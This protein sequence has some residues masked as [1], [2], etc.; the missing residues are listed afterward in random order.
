M[1]EDFIAKFRRL[2]NECL[3]YM[4]KAQGAYLDYGEKHSKVECEYL[5]R[6]A[7][8]RSE[9]SRIAPERERVCQLR[10]LGE[11]NRQIL[12][13]QS[14]LN[15]LPPK[16]KPDE[17]T[18]SA[19]SSSSTSSNDSDNG[20]SEAEVK[21]WFK[22]QPNH[23]FDDV[24][25]MDG[26][27]KQLRECVVNTQLEDIY[28]FF[29]IKN[30]YSFFFYGPP[31]CGKT[32]I[33]EAFAHELM[34]EGYE[35]ISVVGSDILDKYVGEA[36]AKVTR[37]F[38]EALAHAPCILFIDEIDG[39]CRDRSQP[40]IPVHASSLTT[41]FLTGYNKLKDDD[42]KKVIFIG[43]TNYPEKVDYAMLDRVQIIHVPLPDHEARASVFD[44]KFGIICDDDSMFEHMAD[45]TNNYSYR[46]VERLESKL[47]LSCIKNVMNKYGN[48]RVK[49][50]EA[51]QSGEYKLDWD[52]FLDAKRSC[53]PSPKDKILEKQE[54]WKRRFTV[55]SGE[56]PDEDD[57]PDVPDSAED[58]DIPD[59]PDSIDDI[60]DTD[61]PDVTDEEFFA[62]EIEDYGELDEDTEPDYFNEYASNLDNSDDL[63]YDDLF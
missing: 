12:N 17:G 52:L 22:P 3:S 45:V 58:T 62:D 57:A 56:L 63:D 50:L 28:A 6:A 40:D 61:T 34:K 18:G 51:L 20:P 38:E 8:I 19:P 48:D 35:Y 5:Q 16:S 9:L 4:R 37:L 41:A 21:S 54:E 25:G 30:L 49:A 26:L 14:E 47:K 27:K 15:I 24:A 31:G 7:N 10:K 44:R 33:V 59:V 11:L 2:E 13:I 36:E 1:T 46:D 23:S 55:D 39:V 53:P 29:G 32:Y 42:K 60:D 43:A